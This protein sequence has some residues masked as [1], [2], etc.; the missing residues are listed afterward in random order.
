[1]SSSKRA[2]AA[3]TRP[4]PPPPP[5]PPLPKE[6]GSKPVSAFAMKLKTAPPG[7]FFQPERP[8]AHKNLFA[9]PTG[10]YFFY[11]TLA[12]PAMLR[13][14]LGL[15][16]RPQFQ[17]ATITGY[18][19]KLW[20]QYPALLDA[21]GKVVHGVVYHVETVEHGERL[22]SY[23]TNNYRADRCNISYIDGSDDDLGYVFKFVGNPRDLSD[24]TFDLKTWLKRMKRETKDQS[25]VK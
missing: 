17:P 21:P 12:D 18:E 25:H 1:M 23:E 16:T 8:P 3:A 13:E 6:R 19:C 20:G 14:I 10:P 9:A 22:A 11:G 2:S 24:G 7:Y 5:P 15:K 4:P